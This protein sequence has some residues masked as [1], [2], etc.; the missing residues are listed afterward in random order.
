DDLTRYNGYMVNVR[1]RHL[2]S[3]AIARAMVWE[4]MKLYMDPPAARTSRFVR[5][6]PAF[7]GALLRN[8]FALF[9]GLRNRMF[10]PTPTLSRSVPAPGPE[11]SSPT[12][13]S[14]SAEN[15]ATVPDSGALCYDSGVDADTCRIRGRPGDPPGSR[16]PDPPQDRRGARVL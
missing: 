4:G 8:N 5:D 16:R 12:S 9:A 13:R 1:T 15:P 10:R 14:R 7:R 11:R 6:F 2:S 3:S